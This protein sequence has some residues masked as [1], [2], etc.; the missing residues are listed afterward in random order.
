MSSYETPQAA[1]QAFRSDLPR[2]E[3]LL[4]PLLSKP[5]AEMRGKLGTLEKAKMDVLLAY[6]INDLVWS[7]LGSPLPILHP[8]IS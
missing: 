1:I 5:W 8:C 7:T 4:Q 2:L 6:T 3:A